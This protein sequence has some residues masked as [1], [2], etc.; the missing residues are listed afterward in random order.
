[1]VTELRRND[2]PPVFGQFAHWPIM[3][4]GRDAPRAGDVANSAP[5]RH[6]SA[7]AWNNSESTLNDGSRDGIE[8]G[9]FAGLLWPLLCPVPP[10][11]R[12]APPGSQELGRHGYNKA[13]KHHEIGQPDWIS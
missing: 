6:S 13:D 7:G 11:Q 8:M 4:G 10:S 3:G 5:W 9:I 1:V 12:A 2:V